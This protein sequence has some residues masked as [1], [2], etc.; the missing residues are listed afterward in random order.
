MQRVPCKLGV[1]LDNDRCCTMCPN[2]SMDVSDCLLFQAPYCA[3]PPA[4]AAGA[5]ASRPPPSAPSSAS[6]LQPSSPVTSVCQQSV[7]SALMAMGE[8][9]RYTCA[10]CCPTAFISLECGAPQRTDQPCSGRPAGHAAVALGVPSPAQHTVRDELFFAED[11]AHRLLCCCLLSLQLLILL[12]THMLIT[13]VK[14]LC[15][16]PAA[17]SMTQISSSAA[18]AMSALHRLAAV[19]L[20]SRCNRNSLESVPPFNCCLT[21]S[22]WAGSRCSPQMHWHTSSLLPPGLSPSTHLAELLRARDMLK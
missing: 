2:P 11:A 16:S 19:S 10:H 14:T 4:L 5:C 15:N 18:V 9:R 21:L 7:A 1:M 20:K 3:N 17:L 13:A 8:E 6:S 22:V 12:Q